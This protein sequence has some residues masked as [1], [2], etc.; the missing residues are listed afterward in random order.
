MAA[1]VA[2][3]AYTLVHNGQVNQAQVDKVE[4]GIQQI[5]QLKF[6][7][8]VPIVVESK[9]EAEAQMEAELE[10]DYSDDQLSA[11]GAAGA[12]VGLYPA[13]ID[14]KA[15]E[16]KL[17]RSQVAGFYDPDEKQMVLVTGAVDL[18]IL[19]RTAEFLVQQDLVGQMLL[20]HELTHALQDQHFDLGTKLDAI[21]DNDDEALALK[22]VSEGD[23]TIAGLAY[24]TGGMTSDTLDTLSNSLHKLPAMLAS[25]TPG[26][27]EGLSVPLLFQY[28]SGVDFVAEAYRRGGWAAVDELYKDPP[29]SSHQILHPAAYFDTPVEPVPVQIGGYQRIMS[30]W[31]KVDEDTFGELLLRVILERNLGNDASRVN[32]ASQWSGDRMV[33]L[34]DQRLISVIWIITFTNDGAANQFAVTYA[35]ILDRMLGETAHEIDYRDNSVLIVIGEAAHYMGILGPS[36]WRGSTI[37]GY[38]TPSAAVAGTSEDIG[39]N[40]P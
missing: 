20:A 23:A 32:L 9:D 22:A 4:D 29:R 2:G 1:A 6:L 39:P 12:L 33:I 17:L 35:S 31:K 26:T 36:V 15:T 30:A 19:D 38:Q 27:P 3:C 34:Q 11:D 21:K 25:E 16:L 14:L 18:G 28:S 37:G 10:R 7:K 24:V 40:H 13:G 5:R 8:P